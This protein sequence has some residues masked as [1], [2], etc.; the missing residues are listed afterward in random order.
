[1]VEEQRMSSTT[2][3]SAN[4]VKI[5]FVCTGNICRSPF[6]QA[7][8]SQRLQ[9]SSGFE[10]SSSGLFVLEER[11]VSH[12]MRPLIADVAGA[13]EF[14]HLSRQATQAQLASQ[15]LVLCMTREHRSAVLEECPAVFSRAFTLREFARLI[16]AAR[17][18]GIPVPAQGTPAEKLRAMSRTLAQRRSLLTKLEQPADDDVQDPYRQSDETYQ[19]SVAEM[20]PALDIVAGFLNSLATP[21]NAI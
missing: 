9:P 8:L 17:E 13:S 7:Y 10:V 15:D 12:A 16:L 5:H 18:D 20:V 14:E 2:S 3:E 1:M 21:A 11:P 19:K 4:P 6:S